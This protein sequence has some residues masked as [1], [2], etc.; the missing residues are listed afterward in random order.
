MSDHLFVYGTL[1]R[2]T[3]VAMA[4]H[5][6]RHATYLGTGCCQ[7][8]LYEL[9]RYPGFVP[10][11]EPEEQV[12]GDVYRLDDPAGTLP[13]MDEY[14]EYGPAFADPNEYLRRELPVRLGDGRL[15]RA[16][17]YV[18]NWPVEEEFRIHSGD[19]ARQATS[20]Q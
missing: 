15:I 7:G 10:G 20:C 13:M 6:A 3:G 18:Y 19:F 11:A 2:G 1:R 12:V 9:G 8:R 14:E 4:E 17:V 16:W 5:L